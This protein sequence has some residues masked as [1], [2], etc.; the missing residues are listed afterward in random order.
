MFN[1]SALQNQDEKRKISSSMLGEERRLTEALVKGSLVRKKEY[2]T[3]SS[4]QA[5]KGL[6]YRAREYALAARENCS[7]A[8]VNPIMQTPVIETLFMETSILETLYMASI[9]STKTC[10]TIF[11]SLI[12]RQEVDNRQVESMILNLRSIKIH[13]NIF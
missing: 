1:R 6:S 2:P 11:T 12:T 3:E 13:V 10:M 7:S 8:C 9:M 4:P 5:K